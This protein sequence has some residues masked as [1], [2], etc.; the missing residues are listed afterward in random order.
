MKKDDSPAVR[1][2]PAQFSADSDALF[3]KLE[4]RVMGQTRALQQLVKVY[5]AWRAGMNAPNRPVAALLFLG[6]TGVGKTAS[7][8]AL[9]EVL[10]GAPNMIFRVDCAEY[11]HSHEIS[12]LIGAPPSYVGYK[13]G[14]ARLSQF[15]LDKYQR[16]DCKLNIA[17][18]DEIE[19][20]DDSLKDLLLGILD[21]GKATLGNGGVVDFTNTMVVMTSN[22]GANETQK[23]LKSRSVGFS[24]PAAMTSN[25]NDDEIYRIAKTAVEKHFRPEFRNRLTRVI[26]FRPLQEETLRLILDKELDE[27]ARRVNAGT[28]TIPVEFSQAA[29]NFLFR[30][31]VSAEYGARELQRA[32][33]RFVVQPIS[34]LIGSGQAQTYRDRILVD[35][36]EAAKELTFYRKSD[37][38]P[39]DGLI[40][41]PKAPLKPAGPTRPPKPLPPKPPADYDFSEFRVSSFRLAASKPMPLTLPELVRRPSR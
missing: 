32:V 6:P 26:V 24:R 20:A 34:S 30:E 15:K 38:L 23:F 25:Q 13:E 22:L 21:N 7:V 10:F 40:P 17:L 14:D 19:K 39:P 1:L 5:E 41:G 28:R 33:E 11:Q 12:K 2:N 29:K 16:D 3:K 37:V 31:G 4:T 35:C 36:D 18:F 8:Q 27:V 9:A